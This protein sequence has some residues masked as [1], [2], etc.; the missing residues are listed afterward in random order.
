MTIPSITVFGSINI[1]MTSRV[2]ALPR[3]G[4]TLH[5]GHFSIGLGGKGA[6]QA[7]AASRMG[8]PVSL[9]G[10]IGADT[11][12]DFA[13][14]RLEKTT[15]D[16]QSLHISSQAMTGIASITIN[17]EGEN[18]IIVAGGSN[19]A[20]S[21]QDV[22]Y[23]ENVIRHASI[24]MMQL[25]VP[26]EAVLRAAAIARESG[27]MVI[28]D[29][30]P[31]PD[32]LP[33]TLYQLAHIMTPNETETEKLTGIRPA[34]VS[35]AYRAARVLMER[36]LEAAIIKLGNQG[37]VFFS[38]DEAGF[39]PPFQITTI[40]SVA[41]GD[42]FNAGLATALARNM[43]LGESV[44]MAAACGALAT[45]KKGA[46]DAAPSWEEAMALLEQQPHLQIEKI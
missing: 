40:D 8:L 28:L 22:A 23:I 14:A 38:A 34:D 27:A 4:E 32:L 7:V 6:N 21:A 16:L 19:M 12:G 35:T 10:W 37:V 29:P 44:R 39:I 3:A 30:A 43:S 11:L 13:R 24:L 36:G 42:S 9:A 1:D 41:A 45:T 17:D 20:I 31:A 25:E 15:L 18:T 46:A 5:A 26:F 2:H 33:D